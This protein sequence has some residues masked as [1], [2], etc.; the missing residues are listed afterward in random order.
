MTCDSKGLK[1]PDQWHRLP[2]DENMFIGWK[3]MLQ[4]FSLIEIV[5]ALGIISFALVGIMGLFPVAMK[6]ALE[7]QRETRAAQIAQQIFSDLRTLP[8][9]NRLVA[10]TTNILNPQTTISLTT[11]NSITVS[12]AQDGRPLGLGTNNPEGIFLAEIL[13]TPN[14]PVSGLSRVQT[15]IE[16]PAK[17]ATHARSRYTFVTLMNQ[18]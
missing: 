3:P 15:T 4:A 10:I 1:P 18:K 6:S 9:T 17:A 13:V 8:G 11:S 7:S 16:T 14:I 5:L 12:Y 2:A